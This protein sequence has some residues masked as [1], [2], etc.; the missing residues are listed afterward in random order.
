M[1]HC[2]IMT[3][4]Q[5]LP[6]INHFIQAIPSDWGVYV[7]LDAKSDIN[8]SD[9]DTKAKVYKIKKI[10]WG[11]WEHLWAFMHLL[12][13][14]SKENQYDYY[15]LVTGQDYFASPPTQFDEIL[16]NDKN[17]YIGVF[18]IPNKHWGWEGGEKI[19]KYRTISSFT[20]IRKPFPK[21]LN[22][23]AYILQKMLR[24]TKPL[25]AFKLYGGSV[26][27]SLHSD[28]VDWMLKDEV[29]QNL[30]RSLKHTTCS[31]EVYIPTVIMNSPY[32]KTCICQNLRYDD[33]STSPAP[34]Y[35]DGS[36]FHRIIGAHKL[37][38]RKVDSL[39]SSELLKLLDDNVK[40]DYN[41]EEIK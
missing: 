24:C 5:D 33:W 41:S 21:A 40:G 4:Y 27:S 1:R 22:K 34:K 7:H 38:C 32:G 8:E 12:N 26:Y 30:L 15:H 39:K 16:G 35:L 20:D 23:I 25:P 36:D 31:E 2:I 19:F 11:A 18:S 3:A 13:E 14:A 6:M 28:F 17:S 29:S 9:I 10:Y 37:F